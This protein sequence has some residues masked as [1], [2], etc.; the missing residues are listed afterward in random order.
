MPLKI[1]Y[2]DSELIVI[3]K[4]S[5]IIVFSE[6]KIKEKT[7]TDLILKNRPYLKNIDKTPRYGLVHRL[8]K[9]TS[10]I[11]LIAKDNKTLEF[12]QGQFQ[13]R[14]VRKKYIALVIGKLKDNEGKIETLLGRSQKDGKKQKVYLPHEPNAKGKRKA[15]T[16]YKALQ[17]FKD[18]TLIEV[19]IETGRKHQIRTHFAF[20][21]H[22]IAGDKMYGFK[23]QSCPEG[24][25][26]Q[27]LHASQLK[28]KMPDNKE[29]TFK[30]E[31]PSDLKEILKKLKT[32]SVKQ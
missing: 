24:L 15:V 20:L 29:I 8:D 31:L 11:L 23:N 12:L 6:K 26:R 1:I 18:Y 14:K 32:Q 2:E 19:E 16:K 30:S 9:D 4:P 17:K 10:G 21:L 27:F 5:G 25:K 13:K 22:P 7:I 28:I 3:D